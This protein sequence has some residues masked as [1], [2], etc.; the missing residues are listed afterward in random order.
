MEN[1]KIKKIDENQSIAYLYGRLDVLVSGDIEEKIIENLE[2]E[3][4]KYLILNMENVEY[5]SSSGFR[6]A[7]ALLRKLKEKKG[8]LRVCSIRPSVK[9]IF[10]VIELDSLF[11]I[12]E[13]EEE[14]LEKPY[15]S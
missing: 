2:S 14:A 13:T 5:M 11:E 9:R 3:N 12:Y 10:D 1:V 15:E 8:M 6:V 7:I 4:V